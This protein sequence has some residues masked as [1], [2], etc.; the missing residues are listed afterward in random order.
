MSL[1]SSQST[2]EK[3]TTINE[4]ALVGRGHVP[5]DREAADRQ[6]EQACTQLVV[7]APAYGCTALHGVS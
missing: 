6:H 7:S 3:R 5:A 2:R 1:R 4:T